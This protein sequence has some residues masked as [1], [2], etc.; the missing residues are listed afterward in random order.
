MGD[1]EQYKHGVDDL[2]VQLR[3]RN[4]D[5]KVHQ[6]V[7]EE[8]A[9]FCDNHKPNDSEYAVYIVECRIDSL[10]EFVKGVN[11]EHG[12]KSWED[13]KDIFG[14]D[15]TKEDMLEDLEGIADTPDTIE[16]L[17]EQT[18]EAEDNYNAADNVR[19]AQYAIEADTVYYVGYTSDL[20]RRTYEHVSGQ[21]AVFTQIVEP[22]RL[23]D[24][25]WFSSQHKAKEVEKE[26]AH[27][28]T[29]LTNNKREDS[30]IGLK[31]W[32]KEGERVFA[33]QS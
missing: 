8:V 4:D 28:L 10:T 25:Y 6:Y 26:L 19:W 31:E 3:H 24:V 27:S 21:G 32:N 20:P 23:S 14:E 12:Q 2:P 29:T 16:E 9:D 22:Q 18:E 5:E 13:M 1:Y 30:E 11:K 33:K 17:E 15:F 7:R